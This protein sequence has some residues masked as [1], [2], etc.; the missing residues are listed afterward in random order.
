MTI[1]VNRRS[2]IAGSGEYELQNQN[3]IDF[4]PPQQWLEFYK[5]YNAI[6]KI[7]I[8]FIYYLTGVLFYHHYEKWDILGCVYFITV[9]S[10]TIGYGFFHPTMDIT[11]AFTIIYLPIGATIIFTSFYEFAH[12]VLVSAQDE[13]IEQFE[14]RIRKND[15]VIPEHIMK[16]RRLILSI[17]LLLICALVGTLFYSDNEDWSVLDALYWTVCTMT[18][19]G[20]GTSQPSAAPFP[21]PPCD[22]ALSMMCSY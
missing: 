11:R 8:L 17:M 3:D 18:T 6:I 2:S 13:V 9:S 7:A 16:K 4:E 21:P 12:V 22:Q 19:V 20:Y 1:K 15:R 10:T 5:K 14:R